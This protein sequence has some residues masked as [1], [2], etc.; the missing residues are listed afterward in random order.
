MAT[1]TNF[2]VVQLDLVPVKPENQIDWCEKLLH[3]LKNAKNSNIPGKNWA[4]HTL[5]LILR[6][7]KE[8]NMKVHRKE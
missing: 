1:T 6:Y 5:N 7:Q 8:I 3:F 4:S 2:S